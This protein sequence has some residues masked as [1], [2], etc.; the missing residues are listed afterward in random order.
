[1]PHVNSRRDHHRVRYA[2]VGHGRRR[3]DIRDEIPDELRSLID[4]DDTDL[5]VICD[6]IVLMRAAG[7]DVTTPDG[8]RTCIEAGRRRARD[9]D[10]RVH[11]AV[12][13]HQ[14]EQATANQA[15][16]AARLESRAQVYYA[17]TGDLVKIG[18]TVH[19][20][21]RM[22]TVAPWELLAAEPGGPQREHERHVQFADLR[23]RGEW[24]RYQGPLVPHVAE[25]RAQFG[26]PSLNRAPAP[27]MH[28]TPS[29]DMPLLTTAEAAKIAGVAE[30]TIRSWGSRVRVPV[31][32]Y[33]GG[34]D[35]GEILAYR[36]TR[37]VYHLKPISFD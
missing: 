36:N 37:R 30:A 25:M 15:E 14:R 32:R 26:P 21:A 8:L 17:R 2:A 29:R 18:Y 33:P 11:P 16:V 12:Q 28:M 22:A 31:T 10:R 5:D 34:W 13:A 24:F 6:S 9:L 4:I 35:V 23:M 27:R 3:T 20:A 7:F 1:M 19:L